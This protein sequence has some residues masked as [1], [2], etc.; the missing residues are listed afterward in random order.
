MCA[1]ALRTN[2]GMAVAAEIGSSGFVEQ[3]WYS[4]KRQ[5]DLVARSMTGAK[6]MYTR[7][8]FFNSSKFFDLEFT[9]V[10]LPHPGPGD[11]EYF[12]SIPG[13]RVSVRLIEHHG[14]FAGISLLGSRWRHELFEQWIEEAQPVSFVIENLEKAQFDVE[15]GRVPMSEVRAQLKRCLV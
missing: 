2:A 9:T 13:R 10:G 6:V 3:L 4:A 12:S 5:G 8:V 11:R 14:A 7:P 15:F 1:E